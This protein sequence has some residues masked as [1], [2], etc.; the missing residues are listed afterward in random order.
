MTNRYR[1]FFL[2]STLCLQ[3]LSI[4]LLGFSQE[5]PEAKGDEPSER[6]NVLF[7]LTDDQRWD[8]LSLAGHRHLKTP[9]I[10]RIGREGVYFRNAFCT[11]SLCSPSRA[12][13]LSGLTAFQIATLE[14]FTISQRIPLKAEI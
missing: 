3:L 11:T 1:C 8:A 4:P 12:S 7:I 6:P 2:F 9:N 10:D 14:S 13:I 5:D